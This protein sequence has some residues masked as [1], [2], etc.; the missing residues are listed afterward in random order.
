MYFALLRTLV[1]DKLAGPDISVILSSNQCFGAEDLGI[2]VISCSTWNSYE[3][4]ALHM[5]QKDTSRIVGD[6]SQILT[7]V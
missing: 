1:N 4:L 2:P 5:E 6:I 3:Y 7:V